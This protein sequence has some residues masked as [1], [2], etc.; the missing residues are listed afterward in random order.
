MID[1]LL[2]LIF[3]IIEFGFLLVIVIKN[4]NHPQFIWIVLL[5]IFLQLYQLM[6]FFLC[7][8]IEPNIV[9][10]L[11]LLAITF[12]PPLGVLLTSDV[13]HL[14][15]WINWSGI[16]VGIGLSLFY[17]IVPNAFTFQTCNPF[18]A[19]Y[20]YPLGNF[21]GIFYFGYIGW[22][23]VLLIIKFIRNRGISQKNTNKKATYILIGYLSFLLPM[24][25]TLIIDT[26]TI[27]ALESIMCKYAILLAIT[28]FTF[29]FQYEKKDPEY[30]KKN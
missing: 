21:Y 25:V 20:A 15:H 22:A 7:I 12:L 13:C 4:R 28:L 2:S 8:G 10:R 9:G 11:G 19:T 29:S 27:D 1:G 14:K 5:M 30:S 17:V 18:Y 23:F 26:S 24:G 6:E 16:L 3:F